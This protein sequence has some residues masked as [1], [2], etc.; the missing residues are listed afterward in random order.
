[1][2]LLTVRH[3]PLPFR[4]CHVSPSSEMQH[5]NAFAH[6]KKQYRLCRGVLQGGLSKLLSTLLALEELLKEIVEGGWA[7]CKAGND[8]PLVTI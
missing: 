3:L 4:Q 5:I 2:T 1:M 6:P 7:A 8:T